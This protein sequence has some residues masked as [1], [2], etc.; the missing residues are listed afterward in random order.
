MDKT[1]AIKEIN[2]EQIARKTAKAELIRLKAEV[3]IA[4]IMT[5][6]AQ[7]AEGIR[8]KAEAEIDRIT[9]KAMKRAEAIRRRAEAEASMKKAEAI[10][11]NPCKL[12]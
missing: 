6:T 3:E 8:L 4:R 2:S 5:A 10:R 1:K 11:P 12:S 9:A 7:K